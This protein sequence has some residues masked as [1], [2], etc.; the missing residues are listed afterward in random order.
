MCAA[1]ATLILIRH[2]L[3]GLLLGGLIAVY[4][5]GNT[6]LHIKRDDFKKETLYEYILVGA[7]VF[8]VIFSAILH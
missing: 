5:L 3:P 1:I 7:S 8:I 4:V 6:F 2:D